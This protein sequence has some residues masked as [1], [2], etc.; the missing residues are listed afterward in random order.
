MKAFF[1][2]MDALAAGSI[3]ML[4]MVLMFAQ[5]FHPTA[6]RGVYL[7]HLSMDVLG[8]LEHSGR[9][10][11]MVEGNASAVREIFDALPPSV[12]MEL[13]VN[14][15]NGASLATVARVKCGEFGRELQTLASPLV[16][17]DD[18]YLVTMRSWYRK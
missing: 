3:M 17:G 12:C 8:T 10:G 18:L 13:T 11:A 4:M 1:L 2:S 15:P 6:P 14:T 16:D 5:D 7:K 9:L